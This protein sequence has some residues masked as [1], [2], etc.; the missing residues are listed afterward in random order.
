MCE[1]GMRWCQPKK[2]DEATTTTK[3][4]PRHNPHSQ[5]VENSRLKTSDRVPKNPTAGRDGIL[6]G[7]RPT[8]VTFAGKV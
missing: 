7:L 2:T 8:Y 4:T 3:Q 6:G 1:T 5:R